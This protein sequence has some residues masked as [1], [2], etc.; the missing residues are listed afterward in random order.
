M[1]DE[2]EERC[3]G[4][5]AESGIQT[6]A[7]ALALSSGLCTQSARKEVE[8]YRHN[9]ASQRSQQHRPNESKPKEE[10]SCLSIYLQVSM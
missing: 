1:A 8:D 3:A 6:N 4:S 10:L 9:L 7:L 5:E 2:R